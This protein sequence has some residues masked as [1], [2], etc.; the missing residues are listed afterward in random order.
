MPTAIREHLFVPHAYPTC[1]GT[2]R[3]CYAPP[4][5]LYSDLAGG[6][7][8]MATVWLLQVN[9]VFLVFKVSSQLLA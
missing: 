6:S 1:F 2:E 3:M 8:R 9:V 4:Q 5:Q 7:P